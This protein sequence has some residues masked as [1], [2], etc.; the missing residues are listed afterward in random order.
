MQT[1]GSY[2]Q[3]SIHVQHFSIFIWKYLDLWK[4]WF[5]QFW[6]GSE[7]CMF[8]HLWKCWHFQMAPYCYKVW[9]YRWYLLLSQHNDLYRLLVSGLYIHLLQEWMIHIWWSKIDE[10]FVSLEA[11][12]LCSTLLSPPCI[13]SYRVSLYLTHHRGLHQQV[14]LSYVHHVMYSKKEK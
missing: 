13:E 4:C 14:V 10:A 12:F 7:K 3:M 5:V 1:R 8:C 2:P 9:Y 11:H 6:K